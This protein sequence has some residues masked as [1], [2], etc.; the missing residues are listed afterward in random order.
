MKIF[1]RIKYFTITIILFLI[2]TVFN[3]NYIIAKRSVTEKTPPQLRMKWF[4]TH[5][6]MKKISPFNKLPWQFLGPKNIS[7]RMTDLAVVQPKGEN[8]TIYVAGATGGVWKTENEGTT[9]KPVFEQEA[10]ASI[11]DIAIDPSDQQTI[12]VGTGEANIFRSSNAGSGIYKSVNSG[13]TWQH[14]GLTDTNTISRIVINPKNSDII[15]VAASGHEWTNNRERGVYKTVDG[16]KNWEKVLYVDEMTGAIDLLMDPGNPDVLYASFWQ[17]V[18]KKWN[19]PRNEKG[20]TGSGIYKT[21]NGGKNWKEVN[22]GLPKPEF[23]GRIGIDLCRSKPNI[24]YALI[25]NYE[26][27]REWNKDE[28]DSYG[29]PK[30][31]LIKGATIYRS[32]DSGLNWKQVSKDNNYMQHLSSTYGWVFGQIRVDPVNENKIYVMGLALNMSEDGGKTFKSIGKMHG[33]HHG[34][35]IDP[36][37]TNY[38]VNVNDGGL[39]ISYDGGKN[40]RTYIESMPLIQFFNV[41]NDMD[42]PFHVY[43]SVQDHGSFRCTVDLSKGRNHIPAVKWEWAPGGEGSNHAPD[44]TDPNTVYSA[45][46]YGHITRTDMK[47]K[48][49]KDIFPKKAK[50]EQPYRGQW[51]APFIISPH[52]HKEIFL[53][54]NFLFKSTDRGETWQKI[55][56]DLT[57][58]LSY[59]KGDIPYQTIFSISES[60]VKKDIIYVGTDDGRVHITKN[61]G[62]QWKEIDK[63]LPYRKWVS[64]IVASKYSEGTVYM[65]QNGKR[66]DDF[67]AYIWKSVNY[68]RKWKSIVSN[69]PC[70]PVNVIREDPVN[71]NILYVGTDYGVYVTLNG[72]KLWYSLPDNLPNA[73]IHDLVIQPIENILVAATH[74]RGMYAMDV[75]FLQKLAGQNL[76]KDLYLFESEKAKI[77]KRKWWFWTGGINGNIGFYLKKKSEVKIKIVNSSGESV[78][79]IK[80]KGDP[81]LNFFEWDLKK[82]K[83]DRRSPF[84]KPGVYTIILTSGDITAEGKIEVIK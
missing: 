70:G 32:N 68:G 46:F 19:D 21:T 11:G 23:R 52:N 73:Y 25:D 28:V 60:P 45:G 16:G 83:K 1:R 57:Y 65:T 41:M 15:Y 76:D 29:R 20:Y 62:K 80:I 82:N 10:S 84:V 53:G 14:M 66:D 77:P 51:L 48:Y 54:L 78:K 26:V 9:W 39:A 63:G 55:S 3:G 44:P 47:T 4:G 24:V 49:Q 79:D 6:N 50:G 22:R 69:I 72:G 56:P 5:M 33:D 75:T 31:G 38:L 42:K 35:W 12:W 58:N 67:K 8:Y 27:V 71:K 7:G 81:G 61:G 13:K 74:G 59:M 37:N 36:K 40:F 18:R 30:M 2:F 17:R 34:L 64:R 43:G